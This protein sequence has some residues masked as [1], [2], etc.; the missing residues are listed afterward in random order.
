MDYCVSNRPT[1]LY[2]EEVKCFALQ[3]KQGPRTE[4]HAKSC[5]GER[6]RR[7]EER[8][9]VCGATL[10]LILTVVQPALGEAVRARW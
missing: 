8:G 10:I 9:S 5:P 6:E 7:G 2:T 4:T 3:K 1:V